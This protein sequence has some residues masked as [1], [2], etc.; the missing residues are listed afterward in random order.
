M[1]ERE[2]LTCRE[3]I[4]F[5]A[6]Y[7]DEELPDDVRARFDAH[8]S[9]CPACVSYLSSYRETLRLEQRV[10]CDDDAVPDEVPD[11]LVSAILAARRR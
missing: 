6:A 9:V 2:L 1:S 11:E 7:L 8:L 4:D 10:L 3:L 5:I